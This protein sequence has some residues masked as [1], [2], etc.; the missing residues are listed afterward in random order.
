MN[1]MPTA[2]HKQ[3][4]IYSIYYSKDSSANKRRELT[5]SIDI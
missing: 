3:L 2:I 4:E 5:A 1:K